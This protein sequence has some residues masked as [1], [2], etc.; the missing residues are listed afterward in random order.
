M[1]P[2][3][4]WLALACCF[5]WVIGLYMGNNT[6][7]TDER[8]GMQSLDEGHS[9]HQTPPPKSIFTRILDFLQGLVHHA[10]LK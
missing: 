5:A 6:M 8:P 7:T 10:G 1:P 9:W 4:F 2:C 3:Y